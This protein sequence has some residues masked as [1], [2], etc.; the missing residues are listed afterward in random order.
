MAIA[1]EVVDDAFKDAKEF[2]SKNKERTDFNQAAAEAIIADLQKIANDNSVAR[3]TRSQALVYMSGIHGRISDKLR[4]NGGTAHGKKALACLKLAINLD[5][6][7]KNAG[8][9]Y[10]TTIH[11]MIKKNLVTRKFIE[12][13]MGID[14]EDEAKNAVK[15]LESMGMKSFEGYED[16]K[17]F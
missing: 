12:G 4:A 15:V 16:L 11:R 10:A 17:N 14:L 2:L 6:Q 5:G 9:A 1:N 13:G 3:P 7:N 8:T